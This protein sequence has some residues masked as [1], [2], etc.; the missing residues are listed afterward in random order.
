MTDV[1]KYYDLTAERTAREWYSNDILMPTHNDL[2]SLLPPKPKILD[3]GCGPGYECKR[4]HSL[5]AEMTGID[6][7][8]KSIQIA[9]LRNP[10][11]TFIEMDFFNIDQSIGKFDAVLA[12]GS[13][14]H[15]PQESMM[16]V[17]SSI[18]HLLL[19]KGILAAIIKD[20]KGRIVSHPMIDN[21]AMERIIHLYTETEFIDY[22][23]LNNLCYLRN[24]VLDASL[25]RT[26]WRCYL[27]QKR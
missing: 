23:R 2:M 16:Q 10:D 17:L 15:V 18:N 5:G 4:L 19:D 1:R 6:I 11:C 25:K 12:S 20:G 14:I 24:G 8:P 26:G 27:F 9:R 22:C 13:L 21:V 7:S 3:F